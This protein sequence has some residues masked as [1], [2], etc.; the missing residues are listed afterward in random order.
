MPESKGGIALDLE[1]LP[2][3][4]GLFVRFSVGSKEHDQWG[5]VFQAFK[6]RIPLDYRIVIAKEPQWI[7]EV[8]PLSAPYGEADIELA[9]SEVF[10]NF[11]S[12]LVCWRESPTLPGMEFVKQ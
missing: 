4:D 1:F 10:G 12:A 7:W 5:R 6:K 11:Y 9:L 8:G 2:K 3:A